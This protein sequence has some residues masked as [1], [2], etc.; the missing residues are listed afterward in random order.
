MGKRTW[1]IILTLVAVTAASPACGLASPEPEPTHTPT[2]LPTDAPV[3]EDT[4]A[5]SP[6]DTP[7]PEDTPTPLPT[8]TPVVTDTPQATP[9]WQFGHTW[10]RPADGIV[11]VYVMAGEFRMGSTDAE[12]DAALELCSQYSDACWCGR[13]EREQPAHMVALDGFWID[14]N[15]VTNVQYARCVAV[16]DCEEPAYSGDSLFNG[17][18]YPV[19]GVNWHNAAAYCQWAG[20]RLPTEAEWEYAARGPERGTFPWGERFD[21]TRL[22]FCDVN[23]EFDWRAAEYDD[24]YRYTAPVGSYADGASWYGALDMAGKVWERVA[25]WYGGY[26]GARQVNPTGPSSGDHKG[27]RGGSWDI[28]PSNTRSASRHRGN[29][30]VTWNGGGFRCARGSG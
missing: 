26:P 27:L 18:D 4:P 17:P 6:T 12:V 16:G 15:A 25:D 13:F 1:F 3:S 9:A 29:P 8:D 2:P 10:T 11:M 22:N 28:D 7:V 14:R 23:C 21:R 30:D 20:A 5:P 19:V 24:G